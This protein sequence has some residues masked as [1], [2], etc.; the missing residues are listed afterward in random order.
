MTDLATARP[1][2]GTGGASVP[3]DGVELSRLLALTRLTAPQAVEVGA[4]VLAG[5]ARGSGS[6]RVGADGRVLPDPGGPPATVAG[7]AAVL[8][9]IAEAARIPGRRADPLLDELDRAGS[10]LPEAGVTAGAQRLAEAAAGIDRS[11]VRAGLAALVGACAGTAAGVGGAGRAPSPVVAASSGPAGR[12]AW[13]PGRRI[14]AW[15]LSVLVLAAVVLV[16]VGVLRDKISTDIGLLLDAGRGGGTTSSAH[17]PDGLPVR[18]PA[19]AAAGTV[20]G[21]ELRAL[22][23]CAPGAPC[24]VRLLVRLEPRA[25][26]QVVTWSY[27]LADRCT[28][29][30]STVPGGTVTVP[31]NGQRAVVVGTVALPDQPAVAVVA[32]TALPAAAASPPV[33]VGSCRG[34]G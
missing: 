15:V 11:A 1:D 22:A 17:K 6:F 30:T 31:S 26:P 7:V 25:E 10:D 4:G 3:A 21:V 32:V 33:S 16:E 20:S 13:N 23:P 19:P 8:G 29:A 14:T 27:L 34:T 12:E 9:Q 18:A 24:T 28:G 2:E 5:A